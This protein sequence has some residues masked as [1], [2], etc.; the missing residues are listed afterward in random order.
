MNHEHDLALPQQESAAGR[1]YTPEELAEL[2]GQHQPTAEQAAIISSELAPM[3]VIAGAGSG[4]TATM[5]D[6]VVWL[7]ANGLVRPD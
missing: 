6:R 2:L 4:K 3:L 7:V 1:R 5:A